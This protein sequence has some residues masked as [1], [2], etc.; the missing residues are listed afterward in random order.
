MMLQNFQVYI[1]VFWIHHFIIYQF[2]FFV[3]SLS[4]QTKNK[5]RLLFTWKERFCWNI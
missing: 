3:N 5:I 1:K 4:S 2:F